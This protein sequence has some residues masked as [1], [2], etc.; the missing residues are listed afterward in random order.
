M[1]KDNIFICKCANAKIASKVEAVLNDQLAV[2]VSIE[3][4]DKIVLHQLL[5]ESPYNEKQIGIIK[6]M[7][8][9]ISRWA[10]MFYASIS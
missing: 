9:S 7:A 3:G 2:G 8:K 10:T 5:A 4:Y 1:S 6:D